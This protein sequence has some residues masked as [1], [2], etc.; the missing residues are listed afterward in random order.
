MRI[1][2]SDCIKIENSYSRDELYMI[3]LMKKPPDSVVS[4]MGPT[5]ILH[6]GKKS[7]LSWIS[8]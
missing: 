3:P 6:Q 7:D 8:L 1:I 5:M 2:V 4:V